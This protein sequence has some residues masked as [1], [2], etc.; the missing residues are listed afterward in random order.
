VGYTAV[1]DAVV[2]RKIP[3]PRRKSNRRTPI[4]QPVSTSIIYRFREGVRLSQTNSVVETVWFKICLI[5]FLFR[6][7]GNME[8]IVIAFQHCLE[9]AF[10]KVLN[11]LERI[12]SQSLLTIL[13]YR[14]KTLYRKE[15]R[16]TNVA[17]RG[18]SRSKHIQ[19]K[20]YGCVSPAECM[21][22]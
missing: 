2:K 7:V 1:L 14:A 13:I 9:Y 18:W 17:S 10:G 12:S 3:S 19:N 21:A 16:R 6:M 4:V 8:F 20:V 5:H 11:W 22:K 15:R